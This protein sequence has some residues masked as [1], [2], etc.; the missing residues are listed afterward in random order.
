M[1]A[2]GERGLMAVLQTLV[3]QEVTFAVAGN[4]GERLKREIAKATGSRAVGVEDADFVVVPSGDS[5]GAVIR[6]K[7]GSLEY[8]DAGATIIYLVDDLDDKTGGDPVCLL[9]GPGIE[10]E[11][12][13]SITGLSR[14]ELILLR[15]S[16]AEYPLGVDAL[17]LDRAGR[18]LC[19]PRSAS[20]EV[21]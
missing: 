13:P 21:R 16:N 20:M 2:G 17:F 7:R 15:E 12:S 6:A 19:I 3:D 18:V 8:P 9:K 11:I 1:D 4:D 10:H 5:D 14:N